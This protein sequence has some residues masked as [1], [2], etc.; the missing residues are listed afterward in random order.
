MSRELKILASDQDWN[1]YIKTPHYRMLCSFAEDDSSE[2]AIAI[3]PD[4]APDRG[5][6]N[7][8]VFTTNGLF[9]PY[10]AGSDIGC[11][12]TYGVISQPRVNHETPLAIEKAL[13]QESEPVDIELLQAIFF[14]DYAFIP[15][16]TTVPLDEQP[17][18]K[19]T[20]KIREYL[21]NA[22]IKQLGA[23]NA[24]NHFIEIHRVTEQT[25]ESSQILNGEEHLVIIHN[26]SGMVGDILAGLVD[27][28]LGVKNM[29]DRDVFSTLELDSKSGA[30]F[31][32]V[33]S[34]AVNF[35]RY[36]R[37]HIARKVAQQV[38]AD[39][40]LLGD[41][42]HTDIVATQEGVLHFSGVSE[43]DEPGKLLFIGGTVGAKSKLV[44]TMENV[45]NTH[46]ISHAS[47]NQFYPTSD[48]PYSVVDVHTNIK[49]ET[50]QEMSQ[51]YRSVD[52]CVE[53]MEKAGL[54]E[55]LTDVL[56]LMMYK[57]LS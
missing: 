52:R 27:V 35:A 39:L 21:Y 46:G 57:L 8:S 28:S 3:L 40:K 31:M 47:G 55:S 44:V 53:M 43:V 37:M 34:I 13:A 49:G 20:W 12:Y 36:H 11:G 50:I 1:E 29:A 42:T 45:K 17:A 18:G 6:P 16:Y 25:R 24:G 32:G 38:G 15:P 48:R 41:N 7:G 26:G 19:A 30:I 10:A 22:A 51:H 33:R 5:L 14:D 2:Q 56:P 9:Y 23:I 4:V 54:V